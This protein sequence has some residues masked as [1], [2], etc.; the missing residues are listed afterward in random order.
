MKTAEIYGT[1]PTL[2]AIKSDQ[3]I[4]KIFIQ[5]NLNNEAIKEILRLSKEL[6]IP[7]AY[8]PIEKLNKLSKNNNHQGVFAKISPISYVSI[9]ELIESTLQKKENPFF[10]ILDEL[11]DVRNVGAII[12]TAECTGV[13]GIITLKQGGAAIND[14]TV[15]TSTGAIFNIPICKVDHIKDAL[16]YMDSYKV[17]TL[18]ATEKT[19]QNI[20]EINLKQA[21]ALIMGSEGKGVSKNA[22]QMA[23]MKAKLPLLGETSS[24]NVSVACGAIL[25]EMVRQRQN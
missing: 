5:K 19:D 20:Y 14:Q 8:V 16:F 6:N 3:T 25:Y 9:E 18:A 22:L 17:Q 24:L 15:K 1:M 13:D 7:T 4:E 21:T 2:E 23:K 11:T 10:I 12:R